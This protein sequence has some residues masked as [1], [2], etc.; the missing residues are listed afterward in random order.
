M[1]VSHI[2][3][4]PLSESDAETY[5]TIRLRAIADS[6]TAIWPT[7]EEEQARP[8][9][10]IEARLR[11]TAHQIVFGAFAEQALVGIA[12]LRREPLRQVEH[13]GLVW[14]VFVDPAYRRNG[15][16]RRLF[17]AVFVHAKAT[18]VIQIHLCVN[19][20]NIRARSFY[21]SLGFDPFGIESRTLR[22]GE[23]FYDEEHMM[24]RL[25]D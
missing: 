2:T 9:A 1:Q 20:E 17:D 16:A 25:D 18:G 14:G 24:L 19:T 23:R 7:T 12:G 21:R 13:K 5:R 15:V 4:R 10:D 22:V 6:P 11:V 3:I 8:V